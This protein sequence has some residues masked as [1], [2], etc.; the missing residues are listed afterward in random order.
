MNRQT[1]VRREKVLEVEHL[2]T[3]MSMSNLAETLS[4]QGKYEEA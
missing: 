2:Y 1:L 3:L 4:S